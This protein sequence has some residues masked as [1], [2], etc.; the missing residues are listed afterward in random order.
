VLRA[1]SERN[2]KV[3]DH[4]SLLAIT[5]PRLAEMTTPTLTSVDFP[6]VEMGRIGVEML[7]H[8]LEG[9]QKKPQQLLLKPALTVRRST[10][11]HTRN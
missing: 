3:P 5:S 8:T 6:Y 7:I 9:Q 1:L 10:G 2:L 11:P 4:F